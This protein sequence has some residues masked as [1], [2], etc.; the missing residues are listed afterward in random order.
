[1]VADKTAREKAAAAPN[2]QPTGE[3]NLS[4]PLSGFIVVVTEVVLHP[5]RFFARLPW[6]E[7]FLNPLLFALLC[8]GA[9][10]ILGGLAELAGMAGFGSVPLGI[11]IYQSFEALIVSTMAIM[12]A[13]AISL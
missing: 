4:H 12:V 8:L 9:S 11:G 2:R 5:S 1:M 3:F 6:R 10:N 13:G 7:S